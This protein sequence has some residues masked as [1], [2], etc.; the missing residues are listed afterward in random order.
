MK[1]PLLCPQL[2]P[3]QRPLSCLDKQCFKAERRGSGSLYVG[4]CF[5]YVW[6]RE[7][8]V[9]VYSAKYRMKG[10]KLSKSQLN[11]RAERVQKDAGGHFTPG[12]LH[13]NTVFTETTHWH[14]II[15]CKLNREVKASWWL[16][17]NVSFF[18]KWRQ[19]TWRAIG[20]TYPLRMTCT[21]NY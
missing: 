9:Y 10:G 5:V 7:L 19:N 16:K 15:H 4:V 18:F 11:E 13:G 14:T 21:F 6:E 2:L 1:S 8:G 20:W 17:K 3:G 12:H